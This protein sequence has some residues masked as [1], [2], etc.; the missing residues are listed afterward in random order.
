MLQMGNS[1]ALDMTSQGLLIQMGVES[2]KIVEDL[3]LNGTPNF[4][5]LKGFNLMFRYI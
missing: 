4:S 5:Q 3:L 1:D 2:W